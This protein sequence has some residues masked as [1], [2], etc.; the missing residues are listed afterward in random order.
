MNSSPVRSRAAAGIE[1]G[2]SDWTTRTLPADLPPPPHPPNP[3]TINEREFTKFKDVEVSMQ[4]C[5]LIYLFA[6]RTQQFHSLSAVSASVKILSR[7]CSG[8]LAKASFVGASTVKLRFSFLSLFT[9]L[10]TMSAI[11]KFENLSSSSIFWATVLFMSIGRI[12]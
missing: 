6:K 10:D 4:P 5:K 11:P 1:P 7:T 2:S 9:R 3:S 12:I 8:S